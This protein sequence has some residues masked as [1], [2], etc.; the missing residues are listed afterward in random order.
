MNIRILIGTKKEDLNS[1][2]LITSI[3]NPSKKGTIWSRM[4]RINKIQNVLEALKIISLNSLQ[5]SQMKTLN[6]IKS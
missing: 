6:W 2:V 5:L 3:A 1:M 4:N